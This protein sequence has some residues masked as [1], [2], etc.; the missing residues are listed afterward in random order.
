[1]LFDNFIKRPFFQA[2]KVGEQGRNGKKTRKQIE[3]NWFFL[4][5]YPFFSQKP[6]NSEENTIK[7]S[8]SRII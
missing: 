6:V 8:L 4:N 5:Q 7:N 2:A 3:K 1:L